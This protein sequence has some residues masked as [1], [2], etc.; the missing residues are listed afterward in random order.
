MAAVTCRGDRPNHPPT[1]TSRRATFAST[2]A[3]T[4]P[5]I[6]NRAANRSAWSRGE[7]SWR[8]SRS[9]WPPMRVATGPCHSFTSPT[10]GNHPARHVPRKNLLR[11]LSRPTRRSAGPKPRLPRVSPTRSSTVRVGDRLQ[12][13][14][15]SSVCRADA[16]TASGRDTAMKPAHAPSA[17]GTPMPV[18]ARA[19]TTTAPIPV[20]MSNAA[21][22]T[23]LTVEAPLPRARAKATTRVRFCTAP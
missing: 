1:R 15:E 14:D 21:F 6:E 12:S 23:A 17:I 10:N 13:V 3:R 2:T 11:G 18:A 8:R 16:I 20:P 19:P 9:S 4:R 5:I 7:R 22:H